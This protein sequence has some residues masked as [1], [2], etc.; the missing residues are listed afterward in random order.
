M[1]FGLCFYHDPVRFPF[2][3]EVP[4]LF[5]TRDRFPGRQFFYGLVV[6]GG[7]DMVQVVM[8][9]MESC[10]WSFACS[11]LTSCYVAWFLIGH[12]LLLVHGLG[13]GDPC[14]TPQ[15][16]NTYLIKTWHSYLLSK[17]IAIYQS[18]NPSGIICI[19]VLHHSIFSNNILNYF[20]DLC[21]SL[22]G[23]FGISWISSAFKSF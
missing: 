21:L 14:F 12:G 8:R 23:I 3:P 10:R 19:Y 7:R 20:S 17:E 13:V 1:D 5:G 16:R 6:R 2:R 22:R 18:F 4:N 11:L 9:A 15:Q